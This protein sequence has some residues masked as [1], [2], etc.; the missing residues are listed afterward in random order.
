MSG[1]HLVGQ[2]EMEA[3]SK[4]FTEQGGVLFAHG[5]DQRR[6]NIFNV[7][8]VEEQLAHSVFH[9]DHVSLVSSGTAALK[10]ALL[11][12]GVKRGDTVITQAFN[13]VAVAEVLHDLGVKICFVDSD[14]TLNMCPKQLAVALRKTDNVG[15]V[16]P[17]SMLGVLPKIREISSICSKNNVPLILDACE[18]LGTTIDGKDPTR[19]CDASV[20]SFDFGKTITCGEGG[21]IS[22]N[23]QNLKTFCESYRDHGHS[24]TVDKRNLDPANFPG[25]NYRITEMQAAVL[26]AQIQKL[27]K[28]IALQ[29]DR[30][31]AFYS[32]FG[33]NIGAFLR[34]I[35]IKTKCQNDNI[36][37]VGLKKNEI[38]FAIKEMQSLQIGTKNVPDALLW[39]LSYHWEHII[40]GVKQC[41]VSTRM[42][43]VLS[44]SIAINVD[45]SREVSVYAKLGEILGKRLGNDNRESL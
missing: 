39:H 10:I 43:K 2:E 1:H 36:F 31:N 37:L 4:I 34:K 44:R 28:I 11:G 13:F 35:P 20:Y 41:E 18:S 40:T 5:F 8:R 9:C 25:F 7:K 27:P 29:N 45:V 23:N 16:I 19:F 3:I 22:T 26:G 24:F 30:Y 12:L 38:E 14:E 21:A 6:N 33:L 42:N 32:N 15:A 17:V